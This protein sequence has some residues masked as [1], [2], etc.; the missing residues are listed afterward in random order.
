MKVEKK[1]HYEQHPVSPE[2]KAELVAAGFQILDL[3]YAPEGWK[4][5]PKKDEKKAGKSKGEDE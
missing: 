3:T 1:V 4:A 2:R 5:D